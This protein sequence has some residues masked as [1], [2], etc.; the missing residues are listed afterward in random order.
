MIVIP[1]VFDVLETIP[2]GL[3]KGL[4]DLKIRGQEENIHTPAKIQRRVLE[5][6]GNL[7][8]LRLQWETIS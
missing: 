1:I 6:W 4:E 7:L 8:L 5:T 3:V 2:K